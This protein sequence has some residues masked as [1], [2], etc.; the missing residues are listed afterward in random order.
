MTYEVVFK[1]RYCPAVEQAV[2]LANDIL[3]VELRE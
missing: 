2:A 3:N 1:E